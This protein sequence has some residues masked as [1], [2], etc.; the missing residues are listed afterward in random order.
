MQTESDT[1][2]SLKNIKGEKIK[3]YLDLVG[4]GDK[5]VPKTLS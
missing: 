3:Y 2:N 1:T 4:F 5:F